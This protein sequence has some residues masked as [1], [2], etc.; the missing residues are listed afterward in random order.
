MYTKLGNL[1]LPALLALVVAA[2]LPVG[3]AQNVPEFRVESRE[4]LVPVFAVDG[5]GK[6]IPN[7]TANDFHLFEDGKEQK[8]RIAMFH[9]DIRRFDDH[10]ASFSDVYSDYS[11]MAKWTTESSLHIRDDHLYVLGYTPPVSPHGSCHQIRVKA[12]HRVWALLVALREYCNTEHSTYD[13]FNGTALDRKMEQY[14]GSGEIG[15]ISLVGKGGFVYRAPEAARAYFVLEFPR[16][17][18]L[19]NENNEPDIGI[20]LLGLVYRKDGSIAARFSDKNECLPLRWVTEDEFSLKVATAECKAISPYRY[21]IQF[22][23]P[24]GD[25]EMQAVA[26]TGTNFGVVRMP[27]KIEAFDGKQI[28]VSGIALCKH[29]HAY[30]SRPPDASLATKSGLGEQVI[31]PT[32]MVPL[33]S[34]GIEFSPAADSR[35]QKS[36]PLVAYFEVYEPLLASQTPPKVQV[37]L[38]I[39]DSKTGTVRDDFQPVDVASYMEPG[40]S[41]IHISRKIPLDK[42][43]PGGYRLEIQAVDSAGGSTMW[44]SVDFNVN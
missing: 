14:A 21:E 17:T 15:S 2:S 27:L 38:R 43:I 31:F 29:F 35:F 42:L 26:S 12:S 18:E 30:E 32:Q 11:T 10:G 1:T 28:A 4:V 7:L 6:D 41:T 23:L 13:P 39:V 9:G 37:H 19:Q 8:I 22:E 44:R 40:N 3:V 24:P 34:K 5:S 33:V 25:Y 16:G 36:D 20:Q